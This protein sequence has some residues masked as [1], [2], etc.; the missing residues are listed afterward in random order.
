MK[1][2]LGV[3]RRTW[4]IMEQNMYE[5][6][7]WVVVADGGEAHFYERALHSGDLRLLEVLESAGKSTQPDAGIGGAR[8]VVREQRGAT[9]CSRAS[10]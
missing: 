5:H 2:F 9:S 4:S 10:P 8:K 6:N 3:V 7:R 1:P